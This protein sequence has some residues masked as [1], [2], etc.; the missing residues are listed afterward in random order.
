MTTELTFTT[1]SA[2]DGAVVLTAAGEI[3]M[4][5]ADAFADALVAAVADAGGA[6]LIIDITEIHYLDSAGLAALF[7]QADHI[8]LRT[9]PLLAPLLEVSGLTDLTTVHRA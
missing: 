1:G 5:N 4:S 8:E 6:R 2:S 3:D 9:G 7:A